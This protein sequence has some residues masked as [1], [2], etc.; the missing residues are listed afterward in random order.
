[1]GI[2]KRFNLYYI[3][4]EDKKVNVLNE[5]VAEQIWKQ[6]SKKINEKNS[7]KN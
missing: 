6:V 4:E 5:K 7:K 1:M 3:F 2:K